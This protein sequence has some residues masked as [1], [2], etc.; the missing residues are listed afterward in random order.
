MLSSGMTRAVRA[1]ALHLL[2]LCLGCPRPRG[3]CD[4]RRALFQAGPLPVPV[5]AQCPEGVLALQQSSTFVSWGLRPAVGTGGGLSRAPS[6]VDTQ[7]APWAGSARSGEHQ[8]HALSPWPTFPMLLAHRYCTPRHQD[9]DDLERKYWKNL[10]FVSPIYGADISGSLY[11][12]V[13][14]GGPL[15]WRLKGSGEN[16]GLNFLVNGREKGV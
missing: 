9:F 3:R 8:A 15:A 4:G 16:E 7:Q 6:S 5:Q 10:T 14:T 1:A 11:D 2:Q 12:D 13:S